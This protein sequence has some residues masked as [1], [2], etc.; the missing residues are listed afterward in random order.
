MFGEFHT[1]A[2]CDASA[3][4][5]VKVI[6]RCCLE[7]SLV[8]IDGGDVEIVDAEEGSDHVVDSID[9]RNHS[10]PS[11]RVSLG[12]VSASGTR[13][14]HGVHQWPYPAQDG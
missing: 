14:G 9:G 12:G 10:R 5:D 11:V 3:D 13:G 1:A 8:L 2:A 6:G 7:Q 4:D